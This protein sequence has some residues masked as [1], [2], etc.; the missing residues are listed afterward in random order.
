M[1]LLKWVHFI[2]D[3]EGREI[4]LRYFRDTDG[5][6]VDFIVVEDGQPRFAIECKWCDT[7]VSKGRI[8]FKKKFPDCEAWQ[9]SMVG[10]KDYLSSHG[11]RVCPALKYL[12]GRKVGGV[13][14]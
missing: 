11:I 10:K 1:H 7:A 9:L 13:A 5:R 2:Q 6:E 8:Y 12:A 14:L 4:Q 3:V